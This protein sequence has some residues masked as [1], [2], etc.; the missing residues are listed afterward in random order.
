MLVARLKHVVVRIM[1]AI[2]EIETKRN[3]WC[4]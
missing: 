4:R 3:K 2:R 1:D